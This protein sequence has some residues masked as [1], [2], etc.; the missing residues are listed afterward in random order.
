M[1]RFREKQS[2]MNAR[3]YFTLLSLSLSLAWNSKGDSSDTASK[4]VQDDAVAGQ[5][6][7]IGVKSQEVPQPFRRNG[8]P[9]AQWFPRAGFGLFIH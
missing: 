8:H 1:N 2:L 4:L 6:Q 5:H 9:D 3:K 7:Q